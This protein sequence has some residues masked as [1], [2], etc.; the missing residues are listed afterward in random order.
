MR[1]ADVGRTLA[2]VAIA[3]GA[4]IGLLGPPATAQN[5]PPDI[6]VLRGSTLTR[7]DKASPGT[8]KATLAVTGLDA[9]DT[10]VGIDVRPSNSTLYGVGTGGRIYTINQSTGVATPGPMAATAPAGA[11]FG[12]D[13]NPVADR[14]RVVSDTDQSLRINVADGVTVVDG[15]IKYTAGDAGEAT[16]PNVGAVAYT[17]PDTDAAT[18]T[19][20]FDIESQRDY[21]VLQNP[22]NDGTLVSRGPLGVAATGMS[23]FDIGADGD[24]LA[25]IGASLYDLNIQTGSATVV[26]AVSGGPATGMAIVPALNQAPPPTSTAPLT[27]PTTAQPTA[28]T[29]GVLPRTGDDHKGLVGGVGLALVAAGIALCSIAASRKTTTKAQHMRSRF[30]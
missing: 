10:L 8:A 12:V 19:E 15:A 24:A 3:T 5:A 1:F 22:P 29:T 4:G 16:N 2:A 17:N 13:F 11:S 14:L 18:G 20:L 6:L 21:L 7:I 27:P 26:G 25:I 9:G 28:S 23:A 30:R